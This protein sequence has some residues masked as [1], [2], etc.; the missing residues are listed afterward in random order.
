MVRRLV[1]KKDIRV[2]E[3]G[4]REEDPHLLAGLKLFH[5][6]A[7]KFG[8]EAEIGQKLSRVRLRAPTVHV[9]ELALKLG[10]PHAVRVGK[11]R[12]RV[13]SV[14]F[15][16]DV[17]KHFV[18]H[19]DGRED[20]ELVKGELVLLKDRNAFA[21]RHHDIDGRGVDL[22]RQDLKERGLARPIRADQS[23]T[24]AGGENDIN[25]GEKFALSVLQRH[26]VN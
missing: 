10:H 13:D 26:A 7:V 22:A 20:R 18:P 15:R 17:K 1:Q 11:I 6:E 5:L 14:L 16:H 8:R 25:V 9:R 21:W 19:D 12:L 3:K 24:I 4:L 2:A 23:V